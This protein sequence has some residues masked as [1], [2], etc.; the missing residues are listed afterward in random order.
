LVKL[1]QIKCKASLLNA[2]I[3]PCTTSM[4]GLGYSLISGHHRRSN[5]WV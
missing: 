4:P 2:I 5:R 1:K 3:S